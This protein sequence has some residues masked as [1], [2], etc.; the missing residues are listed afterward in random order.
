M[1]YNSLGHE[2]Q[3]VVRLYVSSPELSVTDVAGQ[4]VLSQVDP[5]WTDAELISDSIYKAR[6]LLLF[7]SNVF[8][9]VLNGCL[10]NLRSYKTCSV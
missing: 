1:F 4:P 2:R 5:Y 8:S 6:L 7:T 3:E 10:M 9:S